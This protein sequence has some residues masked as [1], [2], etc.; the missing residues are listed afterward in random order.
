MIVL[1][2]EKSDVFPQNDIGV[3]IQVLLVKKGDTVEVIRFK[4]SDDVYILNG[5][6]ILDI[7]TFEAIDNKG[8]EYEII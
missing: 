5:D 4:D 6:D 3:I 8:E 7:E 1:I 2:N